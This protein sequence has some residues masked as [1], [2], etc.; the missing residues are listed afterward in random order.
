MDY[1]FITG[2][3]GPV[4]KHAGEQIYAGG[5]QLEG[6]IE[7]EVV[8]PV[9]QSY[10]TRLWNNGR[11]AERSTSYVDAINLWFTL[12]VLLIAAAASVYWLFADSS[13][14]MDALTAV[15]IVACPCGL[16]LTSTFANGN[17]LRILGRNRFYLRNAEVIDKIAKTDT[18]VFDKTGTITRGATVE[19]VGTAM[20]HG[21]RQL[22]ASL[23]GQS[24][25]PLSRMIH[26]HLSDGNDLPLTAFSEFPGKG[27]SATAGDQKLLLGSAKFIKGAS[28]SGI[29]D[30][31]NVFVM[32]NDRPLGF[33]RFSNSYREG[34]GELVDNLKTAHQLKV[35]SGDNDAERPALKQ[36]F[37]EETELLFNHLPH[38]KMQH[39]QLMQNHGRKVM[40]IGDGLNDAGA[41]LQSD[42][43][44][45]V[46]DDTNTFSPACD[47][48]LDGKSLTLLPRFI[49]LAKSGK[50]VIVGTFV[51]SLIY[52]LTGLF[53][54]VQGTLSP[55][56]A[57]ILMP[58]SS[59]SIVLLTTLAT[60]LA[61]RHLKL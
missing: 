56:V 33:F 55:V 54:A 38:E 13:K 61:A 6:A 58:A 17:I 22:I 21:E 59:I 32:I 52:N 14:A 25:H 39:I 12:I 28:V 37:G 19:F 50:K 3:S 24:S 34:L 49:R 57:A 9:S 60:R 20:T 53:F 46:S 23:A 16:L 41:L 2:E 30:S 27:I 1:S 18:V 15:L 10:L 8:Q 11:K 43:G 47:A 42:M 35:L 51:L 26:S 40:M 4:S 48:I 29:N 44:I 31:S 45:A 36:L 7:L 5:K